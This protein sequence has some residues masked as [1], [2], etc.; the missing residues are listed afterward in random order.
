MIIMDIAP[1]ESGGIR[2]GP[3]ARA[4]THISLEP[5]RLLTRTRAVKA[6]SESRP[7]DGC[8]S[9]DYTMDVF[10]QHR[11]HLFEGQTHA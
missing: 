2:E 4:E 8:P 5:L 10:Y 11:G 1:L 6:V 3:R 7:S 9:F